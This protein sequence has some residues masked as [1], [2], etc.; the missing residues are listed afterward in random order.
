MNRNSSILDKENIL[1]VRHKSSTDKSTTNNANGDGAIVIDP[2]KVIDDYGQIANRYVKQENLCIYANLKAYMKPS[3]SVSITGTNDPVVINLGEI[4]INFLNPILDNKKG[5]NKGEFTTDWT[6]LFTTKNTGDFVDSETFGIKSITIEQNPSIV[7]K[8]TIEFE[9]IQGRTLL[10]KGNAEDN[11][12]NLFYKIPYPTFVLTVKGYY[13]MTIDYPLV[14]LKTNTRFDPS[15]GNYIIRGEFLSRTFAIFNSFLLIY[16]YVAPYMFSDGQGGYLGRKIL[17]ELYDRQNNHYKGIYTGDLLKKYTINNSPSI[18]DLTQVLNKLD[19]VFSESDT[20]TIKDQGYIDAITALQRNIT[21]DFDAIHDYF[22]S[23]KFS[24]NSGVYTVQPNTIIYGN[25]DSEFS[26]LL[27]N[28]NNDLTDTNLDDDTKTKIETI[29][30]ING[31]TPQTLQYNSTTVFNLTKLSG[32]IDDI[33]TVL[34]TK[35]GELSESIVT[36]KEIDIANKVGFVPNINNV[37]RILMNNMQTFLIMLDATGSKARHDLLDIKN[38]N[39]L[40]SQKDWGEYENEQHN[41]N[42]ILNPF[43]NYFVN[44]ITGDDYK[45]AYPGNTKINSDWPEVQLI[46]EIYKAVDVLKNI[47]KPPNSTPII[48]TIDNVLMS[49]YLVGNNLAPYNSQNLTEIDILTEAINKFLLMF[50]YSGLIYRGLK[51]QEIIDM[52]TDFATCEYNLM[53]TKM[54]KLTDKAKN[55]IINGIKDILLPGNNANQIVSLIAFFKKDIPNTFISELSNIIT[56]EI[57]L[58]STQYDIKDLQKIIDRRT[59][60]YSTLPPQQKRLFNGLYDNT[61]PNFYSSINPNPDEHVVDK[62]GIIFDSETYEATQNNYKPLDYNFTKTTSLLANAKENVTINPF[63]GYHQELNTSLIGGEYNSVYKMGTVVSNTAH[64]DMNTVTFTIKKD[65]PLLASIGFKT[66]TSPQNK[67][68]T[69]I[70]SKYLNL[71]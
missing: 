2:N 31:I 55:G 66:S 9:D 21:I 59:T 65:N 48:G 26:K 14:L 38:N 46:E 33:N 71:I 34:K 29:I 47:A 3:S 60:L 64:D 37:I 27:T 20:D 41:G 70:A 54:V 32:F 62:T 67:P 36:Y 58:Y 35:Y 51:P 39:R 18:F 49:S 44:D 8:V 17:S 68:V 24:N 56:D 63:N 22:Q 15:T 16:G 5:T 11:P 19:N 57:N 42:I 7:P 40:K 10:E 23:E 30:G 61:P 28:I 1:I 4:K 43:P 52:A 12:Y 25:N 13:G 50:F 45:K 53:V 69:T 6:D